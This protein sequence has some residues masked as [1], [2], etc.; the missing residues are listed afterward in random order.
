MKIFK[1]PMELEFTEV[2]NLP[3]LKFSFVLPDGYPTVSLTENFST[4]MPWENY[5]SVR[6]PNI[7]AVFVLVIVES[8]RAIGIGTD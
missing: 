1:S 8:T 3:P 5:Y 4:R 7:H 2:P 6:V